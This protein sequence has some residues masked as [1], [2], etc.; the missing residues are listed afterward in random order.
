MS[1]VEPYM[2]PLNLHTGQ[3]AT[4][5]KIKRGK[6]QYHVTNNQVTYR[7]IAKNLQSKDNII[8]IIS[9]I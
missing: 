2:Q 3:G 8:E 7:N 9:L 4:L 5:T 1:V 6:K